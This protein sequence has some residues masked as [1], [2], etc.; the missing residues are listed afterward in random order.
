MGHGRAGV[1]ALF[2][3]A[4]SSPAPAEDCQAPCLAYAISTELQGDWIF[5]AE[6]RSNEASDIEPTI[7]AGFS[8]M[9]VDHL[10]IVSIIT[11]ES[12]IDPLPGEDRAFEDIGSYVNKLYAEVEFEPALLRW[13]KFEPQFGLATHKLD[14]IYSTDLLG[15]YDNE[16]RWGVEGVLRFE[17]LGLSHAVTASAF[18][19]DRTFLSESV[20]T[21][22]GRL[23]LCD[24]GAGNAEGIASFIAMLEG[25]KGA[26]TPECFADGKLGYRLAVRHQ[27]AG[28]PTEEEIEEEIVPRDETGFLAA[29]T[30]R[31]EIDETVLRFLGE[32]A[33]FKH[34][35]DNPDDAWFATGGVSVEREPVTF[36]AAY[37][38]KRNLIAGEPDTTEHLVDL[39]A[40][41]DL[42]EE[43]SLAGEKWMLAAAY[44]YRRDDAGER[45]HTVGMKLT[46]DLEGTI[47][48]R[49]GAKR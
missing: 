31:F 5:K 23:R 7:D 21:N 42:G 29:A 18:T 3:L 30:A 26:E 47:G 13:G 2:L 19:T 36:W 8:F 44:R 34:F 37:T 33:Y 45:D 17:A 20:F 15:D 16:E 6:P 25:C 24:G 1:A 22:R 46:I 10:K 32:V 39:T 12:V 35:E 43:F 40:A 27:E 49:A 14:G 11:T 4:A 9:P 38:R 41:Y 48:G 28:H